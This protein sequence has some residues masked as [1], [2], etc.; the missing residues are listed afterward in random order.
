[1]FDLEALATVLVACTG[2]GLILSNLWLAVK[3]RQRT[4]I[5]LG[6]IL[7]SVLLILTAVLP[8]KVQ[9][10]AG[11]LCL[12]FL[13]AMAVRLTMVLSELLDKTDEL[14]ILASLQEEEQR[15]TC[16]RIETDR[17]QGE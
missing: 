14:A 8:G 16:R 17:D 5:A 9:I 12:L 15:K 13:V 7:F 10:A 3:R 2:A 1:M 6:W 11:V 4:D